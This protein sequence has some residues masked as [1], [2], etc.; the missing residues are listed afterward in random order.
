MAFILIYLKIPII[1]ITACLFTYIRVLSIT[2]NLF[3][4]KEITFLSNNL[5]T[6]FNPRNCFKL[7]D[8]HTNNNHPELEKGNKKIKLEVPSFF[9]SLQKMNTQLFR[10]KHF[11]LVSQNQVDPTNYLSI[12][13]TLR[14]QSQAV[15]EP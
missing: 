6:I 8:T 12:T 1:P 14:S 15:L 13:G 4:I 3:Q 5:C 9:K 7:C 10:I 11:C 2:I